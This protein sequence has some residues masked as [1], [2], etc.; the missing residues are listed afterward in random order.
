M[1]GGPEFTLR[2]ANGDQVSYVMNVFECRRLDGDLRPD[3]EEV[4]EAGYFTP[5][6]LV[7]LNLGTWARIVVPPL[8]AGRGRCWI[9]PVTWR[10][11][12]EP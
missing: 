8:V 9:P 11:A 1:F 6:E 5:D 3:G 10:P 12:G 7:N 4:L 2:Y